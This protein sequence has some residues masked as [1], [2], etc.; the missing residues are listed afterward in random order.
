MRIDFST[1]EK[2]LT[3]L[4][5]DPHPRA[6]S[7][8]Y[9]RELV[10]VH[11]HRIPFENVS[12]LY[13][14]RHRSKSGL[15]WMPDMATYLD[16]MSARGWGGNCYILNTHFGQLL[17]SLG[18]HV[19]LVRAIGGNTHL[20][21]KVTVDGH[22]FYV[23]VGYGAPLFEPLLLE[24]QPHLIRCGEEVEILKASDGRYRIDRRANGQSF[25]TKV[26]EWNPVSLASFDD[27]ITDSLRDEDDNP[28]MRRIVATLFKREAAYSAIN[29]KLFIKSNTTTEVH[30]YTDRL[31]WQ[32][33]MKHTFGLASDDLDQAVDFLGA[34]G[35]R[36]FP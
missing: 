10:N 31:E 2:Y 12:K 13:Y 8:E 35:I 1:K 20:A 32:E 30:E 7:Y 22:P 27:R 16:N 33:M 26:I 18:F 4:G 21:L 11:L 36:L 24:D 9:L 23:D 25:V 34:R 6:A 17:R 29:N 19:E 15:K 14:Y 28:F 3:L 5:L